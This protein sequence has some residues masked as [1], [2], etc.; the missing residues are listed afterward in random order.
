M[1]VILV[2]GCKGCKGGGELPRGHLRVPRA[3]LVLER[4]HVSEVVLPL[5]RR[6]HH[7]LGVRVADLRAEVLD[8]AL[9][10]GQQRRVRA[11]RRAGRRRRG[12][13]RAAWRWRTTAAR[14]AGRR[15]ATRRAAL[16]TGG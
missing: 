12:A 15:R 6:V 8:G 14:S 9:R 1:F 5:G 13:R 4:G 7:T 10:L 2:R 16:R 11:W 3:H